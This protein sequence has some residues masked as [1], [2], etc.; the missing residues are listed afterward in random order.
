M[1]TTTPTTRLA[2][3]GGAETSSTSSSPSRAVRSTSSSVKLDIALDE[4]PHEQRPAIGHHEEQQLEGERHGGGREHVHAQ[5][6]QQVGDH[7]IDDQEGHEQQ[8]PDLE[9]PA[10]L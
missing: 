3:S 8:E 1:P 6:Q 5:G 2:S 4:A 9:G 7:Q 10:Q